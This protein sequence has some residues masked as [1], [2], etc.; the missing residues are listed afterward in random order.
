MVERGQRLGA[1]EPANSCSAASFLSAK[2]PAQSSAHPCPAPCS[3]LPPCTAQAPQTPHPQVSCSLS[4]VLGTLALE[5]PPWG[6]GWHHLALL[7]VGRF[8]EFG[9][10]GGAE[11]GR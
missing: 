2:P 8:G 1:W 11:E 10:G 3:A 6:P 7:T 5:G 4:P 9:W